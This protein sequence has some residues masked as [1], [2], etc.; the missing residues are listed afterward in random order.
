[1]KSI[2]ETFKECEGMQELVCAPSNIYSLQ[3]FDPHRYLL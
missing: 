1:M 2:D 3:N